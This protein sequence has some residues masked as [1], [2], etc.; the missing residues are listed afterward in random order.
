MEPEAMDALLL[1][2]KTNKARGFDAK[3][4]F[5]LDADGRAHRKDIA[6][7]RPM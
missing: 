7:P 3:G 2:M 5:A 1:L 6:P 4:D